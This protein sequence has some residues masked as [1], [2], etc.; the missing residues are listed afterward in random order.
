MTEECWSSRICRLTFYCAFQMTFINSGAPKSR[1]G[2]SAVLCCPLLHSIA[3][4]SVISIITLL[5]IILV[6]KPPLPLTMLEFLL[7]KA[8]IR[9]GSFGWQL[10]FW[11]MGKREWLGG[12]AVPY[13]PSAGSTWHTEKCFQCSSCTCCLTSLYKIS[14][15]SDILCASSNLTSLFLWS[16]AVATV[17][18]SGILFLK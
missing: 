3:E 18:L 2:N 8:L 5:L 13:H 17:S 14:S 15:L 10:T 11:E 9:K 16:T 7:H 12:E 6:K 1:R 4:K